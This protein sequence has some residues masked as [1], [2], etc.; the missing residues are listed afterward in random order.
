MHKKAGDFR[1]QAV[2]TPTND[3]NMKYKERHGHTGGYIQLKDLIYLHLLCP[4]SQYAYETYASS[5][6]PSA[7]KY[8]CGGILERRGL[9]MGFSASGTVPRRL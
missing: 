8:R 6:L 2:M 7:W 5:R 4:S 1:K 3:I 9:R